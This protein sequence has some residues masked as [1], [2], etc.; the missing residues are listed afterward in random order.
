M[1]ALTQEQINVDLFDEVS[2]LQKENYKLRQELE[3]C[4]AEIADKE[5]IVAEQHPLLHNCVAI[6]TRF[7][8]G[9][10]EGVIVSNDA[11]ADQVINMRSCYP[12]IADGFMQDYVEE[13]DRKIE[14]K[15]IRL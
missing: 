11:D 14:S 5:A 12:S 6:F 1:G 10:I 7:D 8:D 13:E 15:T 4:Y 2:R 3:K 9:S